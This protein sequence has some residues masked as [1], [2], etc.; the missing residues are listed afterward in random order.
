MRYNIGGI[1]EQWK[2]FQDLINQS[3]SETIPQVKKKAKSQWMKENILDLMEK[4]S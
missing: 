4:R 3:A 2:A 1:E